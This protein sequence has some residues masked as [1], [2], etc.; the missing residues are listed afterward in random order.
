[1]SVETH[2]VQK[3]VKKYYIVFAA[4]LILTIVTVAASNIQIGATLG[5]I[6]ALIIAS[7]KGYLV[8][9]NFMH[10]SSEKKLVYFVLITSVLFLIWMMLVFYLSHF[11]LPEGAHY[12]S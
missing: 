6:V 3:E 10:L 7:V 5:V 9:C 12:V 1:M 11:D 8:A 4:L 2:D